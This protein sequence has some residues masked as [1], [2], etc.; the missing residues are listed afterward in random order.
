MAPF[1][2]SCQSYSAIY[3]MAVPNI[4]NIDLNLLAVFDALFD[5]RSV[6]RAASR[7]SLTQPTV[8]GMLQRLRHAFADDL[9][10]RT[11]HGILPTPRGE[12][13]AGPVKELLAHAQRLLTEQSFDPEAAEGS[14]RICASDYLQH[15]VVAPLIAV[16]RRRAPRLKVI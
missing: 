8:S 16:L 15:A 6:T 3:D 11:S 4:R 14:I 7:L 2:I 13:L 9:F 10:V 5:E 1:L 12:R